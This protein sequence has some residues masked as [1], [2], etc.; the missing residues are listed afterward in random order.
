[1][2]YKTA[3]AFRSA[4]EDRLRVLWKK[5]GTDLARLQK[6]VGFERLL[7]RLFYVESVPWLL[8]GGYAMEMRLRDSARS[9]KD[10][11]LSIV[12]H[13]SL[14]APREI[15][16]TVLEL[17]RDAAE[18]DLGDWF[19]FRIGEPTQDLNQAPTAGARY[20]VECLL[21][22]RTFT[23]F[24]LDVG[25]GDVVPHPPEVLEGH[26]LLAFAGI[27]PVRIS[28][29]PRTV[30]F[31][32]K[33]HAYTRPRE[34]L[35]NS[36]VKDLADL[37]L[38]I[39]SGLKA[40]ENLTEAIK[41]TFERRVT[42]PVPQEIAVPPAAWEN[43]FHQLAVDLKLRQKTVEMAH[44]HV[45]GFLKTIFESHWLSQGPRKPKAP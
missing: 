43:V 13:V 36:R 25:V 15:P 4:L 6:R 8:K 38:L 19:E 24:H 3:K 20:P 45:T 42:H 29:I 9:T 35:P 32:E 12:D 2:P 33:L 41:A 14:G 16:K 11:D 31:A 21:D 27:A 1:M 26:D 40:N 10:V 22:A 28:L 30:Q 34:G 17:L 23:K 37:V 5:E 7:A 18:R 39:Q 44:S